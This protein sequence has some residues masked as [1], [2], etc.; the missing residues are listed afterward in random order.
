[1]VLDETETL[2]RVR[3]DVREKALNALRQLID[4]V[5]SG[6]FP[7]LF[8]VITGTPAFFDGPQGVHRLPPLAQRLAT[9]FA[10]DPRFDSPRAIQLRL[11]GFD[12]PKLGALGRV[13][14]DLY[15]DGS[16]VPDR[17]GSRVDDAYID[18][19]A[20]AVTGRL[21]GKVGVAR[22]VRHAL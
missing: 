10:T 17:I 20:Q 12:L 18:T 7:G 14:R 8:L 6:R 21:G 4:E 11:S 9:D 1:M 5:D 22:G 13:I 19:L 15:R 2:Q 16:A 3:G